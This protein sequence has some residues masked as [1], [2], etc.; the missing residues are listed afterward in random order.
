[1]TVVMSASI[2]VRSMAS[3]RM[4][5]L[6]DVVRPPAQCAGIQRSGSALVSMF[7]GA[8]VKMLGDYFLIGNAEL[9]IAGAPIS[10]AVCYWLIALINLFHIKRL[11]NA[12][13]PVGKTVGRPL[14]AALGMSAAVFIAQRVLTGALNAALGSMLDKLVTLVCIGVAVVVYAVLLLALRAVE[15]DDV[16][17]LPKGEKLADMLHL[18]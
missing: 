3:A 10:T 14:A 7:A 18:K 8:V 17:L 9:N 15:R 13:P 5:A 16:L 2:P 1:M 12:L 4:V 11:S 6:N